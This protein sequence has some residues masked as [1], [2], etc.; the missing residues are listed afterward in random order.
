[1]PFRFNPFTNRLD[2]VETSSSP[3]GDVQF[4]TGNSGG[5]V[6]PSA[7]GNINVIGAGQVS[8]V[9]N[10]GTNTL[11]ISLGG[12]VGQTITGNSGGALV[13]TL[14]N[15]NIFGASVAAGTTP[16]ATSGAASTL[17]VNVQ[18]SQ[19]IAAT[20]ATN[21]GLSA[22]NSAQF[23]VD[24]NGFVS[25]SGTG[26]G[27]TITG[28]TGGALSPTAGNWNILGT[29]TNG[30]ETTG[31]GSTLTVAMASPYADGDFAFQSTVSGITRLL[32]V[33]NTSNT[34]SSTAEFNIQ[35]AGT[36]AGNPT[37]SW[38]IAGNR[39]YQMQVEQG[40]TP[41]FF[42]GRS[43]TGNSTTL[44]ESIFRV[45]GA[46]GANRVWFQNS[47][48]GV[49]IGGTGAYSGQLAYLHITN[50]E[51]AANSNARLLLQ[52]SSAGSGGDAVVQYGGPSNNWFHGVNKTAASDAWQLQTA[53]VGDFPT[54]NVV[55]SATPAGEVTFPLTPA[56]LAYQASAAANATGNNTAYTLGSSIDLTEVF[57]QNADFNPTTGTFTAPVAGRYLFNV[58]VGVGDVTGAT[59]FYINLITSN[60]NYFFNI[61]SATAV[62]DLNDQV[63]GTGSILTDM[64]ANDTATVTVTLGGIG[65]DTATVL[66]GAQPTT[67]FSG[68]LAC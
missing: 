27:Q 64:D 28:N 13:P 57:D 50:T 9:G 58:G 24:A 18:I 56:F 21:V 29:A 51:A 43:N 54:A 59:T 36:S 15:W 47:L 40:A 44:A 66:G 35:T 39:L 68:Y 20:N 34:A 3:T 19:A 52:V 26:L 1:M 12:G 67:F 16:V 60:R 53:I 7:G 5:A 31:A 25:A 32:T 55:M 49:V 41:T 48:S 8:V 22:F 4:L 6:P 2:L 14:G 23:T 63:M 37:L 42:F 62:K 45:D 65:A 33:E 11:T 17:T 46:D 38:R 61:I 10:P 30:I